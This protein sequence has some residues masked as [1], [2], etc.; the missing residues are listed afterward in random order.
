MEAYKWFNLAASGYL[1]AEFGHRERA[2]LNRQSIASQ[3]TQDEISK[4]EEL[5]EEF[6]NSNE[7]FLEYR[8]PRVR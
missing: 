7:I 4:A 1:P 3:M 8:P 5:A 6:R 2:V